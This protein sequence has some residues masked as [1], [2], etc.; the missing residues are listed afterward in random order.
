LGRNCETIS[1]VK[2]LPAPAHFT[3]GS[4]PMLLGLH[5]YE[6]MAAD[7]LLVKR[8]ANNCTCHACIE[9]TDHDFVRVHLYND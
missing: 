6:C 3:R 2:I 5:A 8:H 1:R 7:Y 4:T 9:C